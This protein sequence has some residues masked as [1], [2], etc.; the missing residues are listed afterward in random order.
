MFVDGTSAVEPDIE[1]QTAALED[2]M[3]AAVGI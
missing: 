1:M 3:V 2:E